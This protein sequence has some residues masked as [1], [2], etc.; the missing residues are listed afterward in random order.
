MTI[1]QLI[2]TYLL[3]CLVGVI[4]A[5]NTILFTLLI[6]PSTLVFLTLLTRLLT[7]SCNGGQEVV[8]IACSN[9]IPLIL[10]LLIIIPKLTKNK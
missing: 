1:A 10:A 2:S 7:A 3:S 9:V 6:L 4:F 8:R 5:Y